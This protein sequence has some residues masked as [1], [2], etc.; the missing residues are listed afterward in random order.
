MAL[1]ESSSPGQAQD[2]R[3]AHLQAA[4]RA[5]LSACVAQLREHYGDDLLH[6]VPFGS[7]CSVKLYFG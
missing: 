3:L 5:V 2:E 7:K 4:E 6:M 1:A